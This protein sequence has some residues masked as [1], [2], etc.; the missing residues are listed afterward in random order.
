MKQT[1]MTPQGV[2]QR[3]RR[4]SQM[5]TLCLKLSFAGRGFFRCSLNQ[6]PGGCSRLQ[7]NTDKD[8]GKQ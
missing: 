3:L 4:V 8:F 2:S 5:R 1:D 7:A 6:K